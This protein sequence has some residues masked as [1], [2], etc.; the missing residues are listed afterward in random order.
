MGRRAFVAGG[1]ATAVAALLAACSPTTSGS[2]TTSTAA[3]RTAAP[4]TSAPAAAGSIAAKAQAFAATLGASGRS[5]LLQ[6]Y[7]LANAKRWSNLPQSLL[8]GGAQSRIGLQ[9]NALT[10]AQKGS[11]Y[12]LLKAASGTGTNEGWD[13]IQQLWNAD[14]YLSA[15]GGGSDYGRGDYFIAFLGSPG[16]TGTWELQF[17]GH[18]LAFANTYI[19]GKLVGATP[20][21]RGVEPFMTFTENGTTNRPLQQERAAFAAMLKGLSSS[22]LASAK[23]TDV[24]S[25]LVL[26]PGKDWAFPTAYEG[27]KASTLSSAQKQLVITAISKYTGD[28]DDADAA[29]ILAKYTKELDSTYLAYSGTTALT[30]QNDYV[31]IDGPSI[32]LEFSMQHGI[33]LSG[34]HPHSVWRDKVTDYG[35]T[36]S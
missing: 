1:A 26:S 19:D 8:H 17:G 16:D 35:G 28:I 4:S 34:N 10:S 20:S 32:W 6:S 14:D 15:N 3:A 25:D 12:A 18:H 13:E 24:Y 27:V 11:L 9:L 2:A 5:S 31:R 21:F 7:S 22:Q 23:L 30:E 33:V 29:T 36:R